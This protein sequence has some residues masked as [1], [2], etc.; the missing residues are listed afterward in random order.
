MTLS[1]FLL[2]WAR[3]KIKYWR[4]INKQTKLNRPQLITISWQMDGSSAA[5]PKLYSHS[6]SQD[7]T[8]PS[9][10]W[11]NFLFP[12]FFPIPK[13][14]WILRPQFLNVC[15]F[16]C[17]SAVASSCRCSYLMPLTRVFMCRDDLLK[18]KRERKER[19]AAW[20]LQNIPHHVQFTTIGSNWQHRKSPRS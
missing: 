15:F 8:V 6:S 2:F 12:Y 14:P 1:D 11:S 17:C 19:K 16:P 20:M 7:E 13:F 18:K 5:K 3:I 9:D 10:F 4:P